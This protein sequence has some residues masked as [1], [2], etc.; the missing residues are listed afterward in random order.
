MASEPEKIAALFDVLEEIGELFKEAPAEEITQLITD[1]TIK[2][3]M[4]DRTPDM[5]R[6]AFLLRSG[7]LLGVFLYRQY[8]VNPDRTVE[9]MPNGFDT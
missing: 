5:I 7:L 8:T 2:G 1:C 3:T 4:P 9:V 6:Q